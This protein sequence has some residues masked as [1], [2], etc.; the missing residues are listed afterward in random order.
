MKETEDKDFKDLEI[1]RNG[2]NP[3]LPH[4]IGEKDLQ[5]LSIYTEFMIV[6]TRPDHTSLGLA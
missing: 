3:R 4:E 5:F 1:R 2:N 6:N